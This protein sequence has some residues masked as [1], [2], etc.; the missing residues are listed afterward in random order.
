MSVDYSGPDE[1][2][3]RGGLNAFFGKYLTLQFLGSY[4]R[5]FIQRKLLTKT[6]IIT[7]FR[8]SENNVSGR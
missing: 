1:K 5:Y 2:G 8:R 3:W 6:R 7:P 4:P